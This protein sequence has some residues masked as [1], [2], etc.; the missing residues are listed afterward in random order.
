MQNLHE[1]KM[2]EAKGMRSERISSE[3]L[4]TMEGTVTTFTKYKYTAP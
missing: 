1:K 4:I 2:S 3:A